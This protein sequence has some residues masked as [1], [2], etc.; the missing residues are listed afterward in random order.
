MVRMVELES[1]SEC[2]NAIVLSSVFIVAGMKRLSSSLFH[3]I[4]KGTW[5]ILPVWNKV[6]GA[7]GIK[8]PSTT[9]VKLSLALTA[10]SACSR[11]SMERLLRQ[12]RD[13]AEFGS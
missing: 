3:P 13:K 9:G 6:E 4:T 12:S 2:K 11:V 1:P 5:E 7:A 10:T 8:S